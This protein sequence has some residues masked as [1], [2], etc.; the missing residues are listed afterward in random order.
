MII[1][2]YLSER[3]HRKNVKHTHKSR[4]NEKQEAALPVILEVEYFMNTM[5]IYSYDMVCGHRSAGYYKTG[6]HHTE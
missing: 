6:Y 3:E 2:T 1:E 5:Y 4:R